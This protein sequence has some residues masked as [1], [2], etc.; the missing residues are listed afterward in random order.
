MFGSNK[1]LNIDIGVRCTLQCPECIRTLYKVY[2]KPIPGKDMT[3]DQFDKISNFFINRSI[4]FCGTWSDP[5]F[6]PDFISMLKM[7]KSKNIRAVVH[8]AASHKPEQWYIDAFLANTDAEWRFGIDGVPLQSHVY[9]VNQDGTKLFK[10]M[11]KAKRLG[12][13]V[14]W[15]Y[16][17]FN[18]NQKSLDTAKKIAKKYKIKFYLIETNRNKRLKL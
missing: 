11:L 13:Y 12:L 5:I 18:Y 9:R 15:Q 3:I 7:C 8:T 16:I 1:N 14:S 10:L 2:N 4:H 17:L 6:N